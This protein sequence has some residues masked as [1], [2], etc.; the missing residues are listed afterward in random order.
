MP[1]EAMASAMALTCV[2]LLPPQQFH[3]FQPMGGVRTWPLSRASALKEHSVMTETVSI[4]AV[5]VTGPSF[6]YMDIINYNI[7][8]H[9]C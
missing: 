7:A 1:L 3:E 5:A 8:S 2:S 6:S 9:H 4:R